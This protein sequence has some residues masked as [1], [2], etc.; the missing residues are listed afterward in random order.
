MHIY[1]YVCVF[2]Y[3]HIHLTRYLCTY[4]SLYPYICVY[5]H[6]HTY[7]ASTLQCSLCV[8]LHMYMIFG[9]PQSASFRGSDVCLFPFE[10][11]R[12]LHSM[13]SELLFYSYD[14]YKVKA[15]KTEL[16]PIGWICI[17]RER[18]SWDT[19][20]EYE[21]IYTDRA[22]SVFIK[23]FSVLF[24]LNPNNFLPLLFYTLSSPRGGGAS[25]VQPQSLS[26]IS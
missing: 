12:I 18:E 5:I 13:S 15:S 4:I 16:E 7:M 9:N 24:L 17:E 23:Y 10:G 21:N 2:L 19:L 25:R 1:I 26:G 3:V 22:D 14:F 6:T 8:C 11:S 20:H